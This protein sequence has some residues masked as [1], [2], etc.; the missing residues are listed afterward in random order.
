MH[1]PEIQ[2]T[3]PRLWLIGGTGMHLGQSIWL[4]E[5]HGREDGPPP[6]VDLAAERAAGEQVAGLIAVG[7]VNAVHDLSDGG[8]AVAI[9]DMALAGGLGAVVD[10]GLNAATAFGEDQGR[11]LVTAP[12]GVAIAGATRI[13]TVGGDALVI[14]GKPL[15]LAQLKHGHEARLPA[16]VKG[17]I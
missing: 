13:G 1:E 3:S 15:P 11:Y 5:I 9:A 4:R 7:T 16:M 14:N 2:Q 6:S 8:L 12:A 17:E 10:M